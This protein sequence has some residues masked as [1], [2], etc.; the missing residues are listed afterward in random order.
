MADRTSQG[1]EQTT[2]ETKPIL[3][4]TG[5]SGAGRST[6]LHALEDIGYEAVDNLP[7]RVLPMVARL[8]RSI[9]RPLAIGIDVRSRGFAVE[10]VLKG[11]EK[12]ATRTGRETRLIFLDC[13]DDILVRRFTETR[14]R[15]PLAADRTVADGIAIERGAIG[16]LR[17]HA[18]EVIDTSVLPPGELKRLVQALAGEGADS[19]LTITVTSFSF[20]R[21]LPRE[22]DLV[23]DVRFL[24][25]P[26][27]DRALRPLDG[28]DPPVG[29]YVKNDPDFPGFFQ[30]LTALLKPLLPRYKAEG[31]SYLTIA[32]GCT[33]GKHRSVYLA[34][35]LTQWLAS[36]GWASGLQHRD[37]EASRKPLPPSP[38]LIAR[39]PQEDAS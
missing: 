24:R 7:L 26:F 10:A 25:N 21:G 5:M 15:H 19:S 36:E 14:R 33:G 1:E 29:E 8:S 37:V 3:L 9:E 38:D 27:Y 39:G 11:I 13:D 2:A 20:R 4:V 17:D 6:A 30:G 34:E 22:A 31:K 16:R 28:R 32:F 23:F 12:I 18:D 35:R